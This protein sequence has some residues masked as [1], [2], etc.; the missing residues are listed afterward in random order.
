MPGGRNVN[1]QEILLN[2]PKFTE[3]EHLTSNSIV[4][5]LTG[6]VFTNLVNN[7]YNE[8]IFWMKNLFFLPSGKA[9]KLFINELSLWI[10]QFNRDTKFHRIALK[11]L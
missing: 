5:N 6:D 2:F 9:S 3:R 1:R 8:T 10:D 4:N 11:Y 7:A